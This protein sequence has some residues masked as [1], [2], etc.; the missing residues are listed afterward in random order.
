MSF[1]AGILPGDSFAF[2]LHIIRF[3]NL[4]AGFRRLSKCDLYIYILFPLRTVL[5]GA[6]VIEGLPFL[7]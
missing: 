3:I 7:S 2:S 5:N 4:A 6:S 1:V